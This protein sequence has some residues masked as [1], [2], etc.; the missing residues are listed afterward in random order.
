MYFTSKIPS[1]SINFNICSINFI[2]LRVMRNLLGTNPIFL[3][4]F[5][6]KYV[7]TRLRERKIDPIDQPH[8]K[9][10]GSSELSTSNFPVPQTTLITCKQVYFKFYIYQITICC[11]LTRV[12]HDH[13]TSVIWSLISSQHQCR[14]PLTCFLMIRRCLPVLVKQY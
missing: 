5:I 8:P 1:N 2:P 9:Q 10:P 11:S 4:M 13:A 12:E 3:D 6:K 14:L 7:A